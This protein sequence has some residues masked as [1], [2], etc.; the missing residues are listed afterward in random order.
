MEDRVDDDIHLPHDK[1]F[2]ATFGVA[3]NAAAFLR[4][5]LPPAVA[6]AIDWAGLKTVPGSFV[7]SQFKPRNGNGKG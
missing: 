6:A 3:E 1:L 2:A 5:K 4:A 7:D